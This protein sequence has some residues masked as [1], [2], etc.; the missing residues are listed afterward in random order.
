MANTSVR[1]RNERNRN[2]GDD[3]MEQSDDDAT[4]SRQNRRNSENAVIKTYTFDVGKKTYSIDLAL[5]EEVLEYFKNEPKVYKYR[6][7]RLPDDWQI[8][9]YN[10]FVGNKKDKY[11]LGDIL[12]ELRDL[13]R[14]MSDEE[15]VQFVV[16]FVQ[17]GMEYD[18]NSFYSVS[19]KLSYPYETLFSQKGVCSDKSLVLGKLLAMLD[20]DVVFLTFPKANHMAVGLRVPSS[21]GNLNTDYAFVESTNYSNI[22][23]VPE[24]FVGDIKIEEDPVIIP[25]EDAGNQ[26]F[27]AIRDLKNEEETLKEKYGD[28]YLQASAKAKGI[29]EEMHELKIDIEDLTRK[30]DNLGCEGQVSTTKLKACNKLQRRVNKK[31]DLYNEK[32]ADY[33]ALNQP[34]S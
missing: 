18:W 31:V 17:G 11:L 10:M 12:D 19:D 30:L 26:S 28:A 13:K 32:V 7:D 5:D 25:L 24:S 1:G 22:G 14:N 21:Y 8:D 27:T 4:S 15:L 20:Y 29:L 9:Y 6:G 2:N 16:A 23:R 33:N 34:E 3:G